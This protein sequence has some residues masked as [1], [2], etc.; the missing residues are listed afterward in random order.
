[1]SQWEIEAIRLR[2]QSREK[3]EIIG[4]LRRQLQQANEC[5]ARWICKYNADENLFQKQISELIE[6]DTALKVMK[7]GLEEICFNSTDDWAITS[8][9]S[10]LDTVKLIGKLKKGDQVRQKLTQLEGELIDIQYEFD[11]Y[12]LKNMSGWLY[13]IYDLEQ[14]GR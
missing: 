14:V 7:D 12:Q 2:D 1:M 13:G 8:A 10:T 4:F 6:K 11:R 9:A 3:D 5:A